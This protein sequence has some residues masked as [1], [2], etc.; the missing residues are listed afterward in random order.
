MSTLGS[1]GFI[2][3][4]SSDHQLEQTV[5]GSDSWVYYLILLK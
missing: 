4:Q 3:E 2:T 5:V 1:A